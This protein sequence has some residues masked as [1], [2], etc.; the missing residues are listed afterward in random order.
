M[1]RSVTERRSKNQLKGCVGDWERRDVRTKIRRHDKM[2]MYLCQ[3]TGVGNL[4]AFLYLAEGTNIMSR[5]QT[6]SL[7][8]LVYGIFELQE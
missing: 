6:N 8:G 7:K 4:F 3:Y 5:V 1:E 2:T